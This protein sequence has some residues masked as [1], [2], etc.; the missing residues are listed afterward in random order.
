MH[1]HM[2][3][4]RHRHNTTS[5]F[6]TTKNCNLCVCRLW[7]KNT[8]QSHLVSHPPYFKILTKSSM[9]FRLELRELMKSYAM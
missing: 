3:T 5:D 7:H 1:M 6:R 8:I 9:T 4:H 2:H